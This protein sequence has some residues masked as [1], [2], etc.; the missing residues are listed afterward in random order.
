MQ[1]PVMAPRTKLNVSHCCLSRFTVCSIFGLCQIFH[2]VQQLSEA[3][4]LPLTVPMMTLAII[5]LQVL[6]GI[7]PVWPV[8]SLYSYPITVTRYPCVMDIISLCNLIHISARAVQRVWVLTNC[9]SLLW[10][11]TNTQQICKKHELIIKSMLS[12]YVDEMK[13]KIRY[14]TNIFLWL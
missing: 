2:P 10:T 3:T 5:N 6:K 7:Y 8:H 12:M 4:Y 1:C 13:I 11:K 14:I 9:W